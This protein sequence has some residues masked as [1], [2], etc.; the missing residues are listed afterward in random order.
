MSII[1]QEPDSLSFSQNLRKFIISSAE[2]VSLKL[3]KGEEQILDE[4][5][6]PGANNMLEVD[7]H[8]IIDRTLTV[9]IPCIGLVTEQ[10]AGIADFTAKIDGSAI[11]FKV[12]KGGVAGLQEMADTF[13]NN[14]FLSWQVQDKK[15]LQYQP[16]WLTL[17][18]NNP[19]NLIAKTYYQDNS[20]SSMS[21]ASPS[22]LFLRVLI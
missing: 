6:K 7:L 17:Y 3:F 11:P 8:T 16:E 4:I 10:I 19:R 15:V 2:T 5:Y 20:D 14:H 13:T 22:K 9:S 21:I 18:A 1:V 12:I